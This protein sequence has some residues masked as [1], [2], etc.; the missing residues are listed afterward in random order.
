[1]CLA[2]SFT[3]ELEQAGRWDK[4]WRHD[5]TDSPA[6]RLIA[7]VLIIGVLREVI[8][9]LLLFLGR[10]TREAYRAR[11]RKQVGQPLDLSRWRSWFDR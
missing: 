8:W 3:G 10:R 4:S 2:I 7:V 9:P 1:M 6:N 5:V 11:F